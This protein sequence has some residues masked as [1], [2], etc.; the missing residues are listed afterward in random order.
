MARDNLTMPAVSV[1]DGWQR[2][3]ATPTGVTS[4]EKEVNLSAV[5]QNEQLRGAV[6]PSFDSLEIITSTFPTHHITNP[7]SGSRWAKVARPF[8]QRAN[9]FWP[10]SLSPAAVSW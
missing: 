3:R 1:A 8:L 10:D 9:R 7:N 2:G 5:G 4:V 6:G